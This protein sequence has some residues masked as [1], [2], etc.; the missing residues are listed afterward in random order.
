MN[1]AN[2]TILKSNDDSLELGTQQSQIAQVYG[3]GDYSIEV[4]LKNLLG[5]NPRYWLFVIAQEVM[6]DLGHQRDH[7]VQYSLGE[8]PAS[9]KEAALFPKV[10][11][12]AAE[13][14]NTKATAQTPRVQFC[15]K[16]DDDPDALLDPEDCRA[17]E[18]DDGLDAPVA[19]ASSSKCVDSRTGL[20]AIACAAYDYGDGILNHA[21][22]FIEHPTSV[23]EQTPEG[24]V[25]NMEVKWHDTSEDDREVQPTG[26]F[27]PLGNPEYQYAVYLRGVVIHEFGHI[28]GLDDLSPSGF[29]GFA[30]SSTPELESVPKRDIRYLDQV[31]R[32]TYGSVPHDGQGNPLNRGR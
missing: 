18:N 31:Y 32:N 28:A 14:W 7:V 22:I 8:M 16:P 11:K 4:A 26:T 17:D 13:R 30:M 5:T 6:P 1:N 10:I 9:T 19:V 15:E 29:P 24:L 21:A 20:H 23:M 27:D 3:A 12:K 25:A 2:N